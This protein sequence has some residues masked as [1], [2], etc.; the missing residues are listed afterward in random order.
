MRTARDLSQLKGLPNL[1]EL[2]IGFGGPIDL[3]GLAGMKDLTIFVQISNTI[4][5]VHAL[6]SSVTVRKFDAL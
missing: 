5:G 4:R 6:D 3:G 1:R 2:R